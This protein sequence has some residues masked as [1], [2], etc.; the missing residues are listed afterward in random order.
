MDQLRDQGILVYRGRI[1][2]GGQEKG[3]DVQLALDLVE[4]AR[5]GAFDVALIFSQDTDLNGAVRLAERIRREAGTWVAFECAYP[6]GAGT[7]NARGIGGTRWSQI[8]QATYDACI[9]PRDYR[10]W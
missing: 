7:Q 1:S 3:V 5:D 10:S 2:F 8:D 4:L 9:D 6:V